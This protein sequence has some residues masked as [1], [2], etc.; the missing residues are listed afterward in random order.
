MALRFLLVFGLTCFG[1]SLQAQDTLMYV[2]GTVRHYVTGEPLAGVLVTT[3][4]KNDV[5]DVQ[6]SSTN[7]LGR[8]EIRLMN[9]QVYS[10]VFASAEYYLKSVEIALPGPTAEEWAGGFGMNIE[11][12]LLPIVEGFDIFGDGQ[13]FGKARYVPESGTIEW[14]IEYT[15]AYMERIAD[16]L[17]DYRARLGL[18]D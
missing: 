15:E 18:K 8:Y 14:D 11:I 12:S 16:A 1:A 6:V 7:R 2:Y 10:I 4:D 5:S 13:P 3:F 17:K 9:E